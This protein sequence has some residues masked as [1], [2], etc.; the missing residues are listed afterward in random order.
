MAVQTISNPKNQLV[1]VGVAPGQTVAFDFDISTATFER[2]GNNLTV[3]IEGGGQVVLSGFFVADSSGSLPALR[4]EDGTEIAS[5]DFL[6]AI[7]PDLDVTPAAASVSSNGINS[8]ADD[9]GDL[10]GGLG[11]SESL[12]AFYWG[13]EAGAVVEQP[14]NGIVALGG[15]GVSVPPITPVPPVNPATDYDARAVLY[16]AN[17]AADSFNFRLDAGKGLADV[18]RV[19]SLNGVVDE[20][21]LIGPAADGSYTLKTDAV[22]GTANVYDYITIYYTDGSH[23]IIQVILNQDGS[24]SSAAEDAANPPGG[25]IDGEWHTQTGNT[26]ST[27]NAGREASNGNDVGSDEFWFKHVQ[28]ANG[29]QNDIN[30]GGGADKMYIT[31]GV[32]VFASSSNTIST[33][34]GA[35]NSIEIGGNV[36]ALFGGKNNLE[37]ESIT[38]ESA[39]GMAALSAKNAGSENSFTAGDGGIAITKAGASN[40]MAVEAATGGKNNLTADGNIDVSIKGGN[41]DTRA[42]SAI[43]AGSEN[44]L[45]SNT[46]DIN[47]YAGKDDLNVGGTQSAG[48]YAELGGKNHLSA[49]NG[50][51]KIE[52]ASDGSNMYGNTYAKGVYAATNGNNIVSAK[53][54]E[55]TASDAYEVYGVRADN[56]GRNELETTGGSLVVT[57]QNAGKTA[58]AVSVQGE[59][60]NILKSDTSIILTADN[61]GGRA[62]GMEGLQNNAGADAINYVEALNGTVKIDVDGSSAIGMAATNNHGNSQS[63]ANHLKADIVDINAHGSL[64]G[65]MGTAYGMHAS[66]GKNL[67]EVGSEITITTLTGD[68][69]KSYGMF[70]DRS[71][72]NMIDGRGSASGITVTI[73]AEKGA[74]D[75]SA[76]HAANNGV[77]V[78]LGSAHSDVITLNGNVTATSGGKSTIDSG[79]GDDVITINGNI[80]AGALEIKAGGGNDDITIN[81]NVLANGNAITTIATGD[82]TNTVTLNGNIDAGA[83]DIRAGADYDTLILKAG[84][85]QEFEDRYGDWLRDPG[86]DWSTKG[87]ESVRVDINSDVD[88]NDLDWLNG[89]FNNTGCDFILDAS[90]HGSAMELMGSFDMGGGDDSFALVGD[91]DFMGGLYI[92][93][94]A[95]MDTLKLGELS[96]INL[97]L[98][99]LSN[100]IDGFEVIDLTG[101]SGSNLTIDSL[102]SNLNIDTSLVSGSIIN[103]TSSLDLANGTVL[104]VTGDYGSDNVTV[105]GVWKSISAGTVEYDGVTYNIYTNNDLGSQ[106]QYLLIQ[107]GLV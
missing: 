27:G 69:G 28:A 82:G 8:Y 37:S 9:A 61:A 70:A 90:G 97:D 17:G 93:G 54:I 13:N 66:N 78:I 85:A 4:L 89:V 63:G 35:G 73:T 26:T 29:E 77:N 105:S 34:L 80:T 21:S 95:G 101:G 36:G 88:L 55:I 79:L 71:G 53:D 6:A 12:D 22:S 25:A 20:T 10:A 58:S 5:N 98:G 42:V 65:G 96:E 40:T 46:G 2:S 14:G 62:I 76:L 103:N 91:V 92:S 23:R 31:Q 43:N 15:G 74:F 32:N 57:A 106:D 50:T 33:G 45:T 104:R 107:A 94:G 99:S 18:A 84:N 87:V 64:A 30:S 59:G 41:Q 16:T 7:N 86:F 49:T 24:Y 68:N 56:G 52:A 72:L 11:G 48:L 60:E 3:S 1:N 81:G 83:L 44:N 38:L 47:I 75:G 102:L 100:L 51:V 39:S 67:V 19:E